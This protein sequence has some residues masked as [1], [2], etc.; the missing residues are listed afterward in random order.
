MPKLSRTETG[1]RLVEALVILARAGIPTDIQDLLVNGDAKRG[2]R[3][4]ALEKVLA[5][6]SSHRGAE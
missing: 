6:P 5:L 2:I 3:P 4:G 1:E